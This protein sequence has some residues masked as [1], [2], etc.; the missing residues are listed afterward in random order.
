[1]IGTLAAR[2]SRDAVEVVSGDRDLFQVVRRAP[3]PVTVRYIGAGMS[4]VQLMDVAVLRER[5]GVDGPG[6]AAVATLRGDP[7]DG[8][9]GVAGIGEKTAADL[10]GRFGSL[11]ALLAA[12]DD[13]AATLSPGVRR[14]LAVAAEY[15]P[16]AERVVLVRT[17]AP[18]LRDPASGGDD[19]PSAP[20]DPDRL[21]RLVDEHGL[22]GSADR[23]LAA[24][25]DR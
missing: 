15:L 2:E 7:S 10:V 11:A 8:L 22:G 9:P 17:D 1:M 21:G 4:K 13:P 6:Y 25:A 18:V 12:A 23:L 5:Y 16:G 19:L 14:K 20:R 24:L 3:T